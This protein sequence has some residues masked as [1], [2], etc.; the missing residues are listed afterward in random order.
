MRLQCWLRVWGRCLFD[1]AW[2][3][4][5]AYGSP[6]QLMQSWLS[7]DGAG[8]WGRDDLFLQLVSSFLLGSTCHM[9]SLDFTASV[10][11]QAGHRTC[12]VLLNST[13]PLAKAVFLCLPWAF[14][15]P[16][17]HL[18]RVNAASLLRWTLSGSWAAEMNEDSPS[19]GAAIVERDTIST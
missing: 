7:Q 6:S 14:S 1:T 15:H 16:V 4:G 5:Q 18:L 3:Q 13:P 2:P 10:P 17:T 19:N 11:S 12:I 8:G 9:D